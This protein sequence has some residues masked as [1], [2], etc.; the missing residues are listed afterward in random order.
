V[1]PASRDGFADLLLA[2]RSGG[3]E[4]FAEL[5]RRFARVVHGIAL[6]HVGGNDAEDVTQEVFVKVHRRLRELRDPG[7]FPSWICAAARTSSIDCLR[8]RARRESGRV[9]MPDLPC[10]GAPARGTE[11]A[12]RVLAHLRALPE[13]YRETL[14]LRL[15]EGLTGPEIA[16]RTGLTPESVRVN[17]TRG[18]AM[19]RP[20]LDAEGLR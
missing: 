10:D 17:L 3:E 13:A 16:E 2:A 20:R 8:R 14:S 7:A 19:L 11:L 6:S 4:A 9:A 5:Y 12:E 1:D 15:V 18:L